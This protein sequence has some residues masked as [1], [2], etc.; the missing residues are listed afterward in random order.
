MNSIVCITSDVNVKFHETNVL[1]PLK[2]SW[3]RYFIK[4]ILKITRVK[5]NIALHIKIRLIYL[6]YITLLTVLRT[7][8]YLIDSRDSNRI[9]KLKFHKIFTSNRNFKNK[10]I[11]FSKTSHSDIFINGLFFNDHHHNE[12]FR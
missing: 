6:H 7:H 1:I 9:S 8:E 2:C 11:I 12:R 3:R 10:Y 4:S 5:F